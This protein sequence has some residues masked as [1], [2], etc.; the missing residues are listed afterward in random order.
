M[1]VV[2]FGNCQAGWLGSNIEGA[3]QRCALEHQVQFVPMYG[4]DAREELSCAMDGADRLV[5]QIC[6]RFQE[7]PSSTVP[8]LRFPAVYFRPLWPLTAADPRTGAGSP[9]VLG[10]GFVNDHAQLAPA[11]IIAR[12]LE[13][14]D[15]DFGYLDALLETQATTLRSFD[16]LS[17]VKIIDWLL[18]DFRRQPLF[19]MF[20]HPTQVVYRKMAPALWDFLDLTVE[21]RKA[22]LEIFDF[23][24]E[25]QP[26]IPIHP[27]VAE[28]FKLEWWTGSDHR[29]DHFGKMV[30]FEEWLWEHITWRPAGEATV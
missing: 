5:F 9:I 4:P 11:E 30:T 25:N 13:A 15:A 16:A 26:R 18:E 23:Y 6:E 8:T 7:P 22:S 1:K 17:D 12:Y 28:H 2:F 21:Q 3:S 20:W 14:E 27:T 29:Y 19:D 10:D 24:P